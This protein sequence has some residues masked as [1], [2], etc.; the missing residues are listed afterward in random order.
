[1]VRL[2]LRL[3]HHAAEVNRGVT[4]QKGADPVQ[5]FGQPFVARGVRRRARAD[6][7]RLRLQAHGVHARAAVAPC[8]A[9]QAAGVHAVQQL[10]AGVAGAAEPVGDLAVR[11]VC[12][13]VAW[14]EAARTRTVASPER[15]V[16]GRR[17]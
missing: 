11:E 10:R 15:D 12:M 5:F 3:A 8:D 4:R 7:A 13:H 6:A 1:V 14:V 17:T 16:N 9:Q 2:H